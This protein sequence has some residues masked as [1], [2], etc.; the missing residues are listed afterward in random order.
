MFGISLRDATMCLH[1][2]QPRYALILQTK[3]WHG[4]LCPAISAIANIIPL[5]IGMY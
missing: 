3:N 5:P 4:L 2:T 1:D